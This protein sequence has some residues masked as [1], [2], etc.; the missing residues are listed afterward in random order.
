M[1]GLVVA[2]AGV[3]ATVAWGWEWADGAASVVIGII[4]AGTAVAL[5]IETKSLL[6]GESASPEIVG[7]VRAIVEANPTITALNEI[8]TLHRGPNDVLLAISVDFEDNLTAGKVEQAIYQLELGI[9]E[10]FPQVRRLFIEVQAAKDHDDML[11]RSKLH[12]DT[13]GP[14]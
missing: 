3:S 9:K 8:R 12:D 2:L 5:A 7:D 4:L 1:L 13:P 11:A 6:I 14:H 10:R